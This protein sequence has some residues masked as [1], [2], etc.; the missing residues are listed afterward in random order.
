MDRADLVDLDLI[1]HSFAPTEGPFAEEAGTRLSALWDACVRAFDLDRPVA[2]LDAELSSVLDGTF[3]TAPV[4][5]RQD[6]AGRTQ[7]VARHLTHDAVGLSLL[8]PARDWDSA[9]GS[10]S[11]VAGSVSAGAWLG[12]CLLYSATVCGEVSSTASAGRLIRDLAP[13][14]A[15]P[16][17]P[18]WERTGTWVPSGKLAVW[19]SPVARAARPDRVLFALASADHDADATAVTWWSDVRAAP[20]LV[21]YLV[22]AARIRYQARVWDHG[23][24]TRDL[25]QELE[26]ALTRGANHT[27]R[28]VETEVRLT[29]GRLEDLL[30]SAVIIRDNLAR[31]LGPVDA[32]HGGFFDDDR[33]FADWFVQ[34][35]TDDLDH[36]RPMVERARI[37]VRPP[38]TVDRGGLTARLG[39][40]VDV[41]GYGRRSARQREGLNRRLGRVLDEVLVRVGPVADQIREG[42]GDGGFAFLPVGCDTAA[43]LR[44]LIGTTD[45]ALARD[46]ADHTDRMRIRMAVDFGIVGAGGEAADNGWRGLRGPLVVDLK[47]FVDCRE[48]RAVESGDLA[49][50]VSDWL[51]TQVV[52]HGYLEPDFAF[53]PVAVREKE[54]DTTGWVWVPDRAARRSADD[55]ITEE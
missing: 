51:H 30:R 41:V 9:T 10:W 16:L 11:R 24:H 18:G 13:T 45:A 14:T 42:T 26:S 21:R 12:T 29:A 55:S 37:E 54:L 27:L 5:A 2:G 4:V 48:L 49:V 32:P 44:E 25:R 40:V 19:E 31:H 8:L 1:A 39:V 7:I 23:K 46:N 47:R 36:L 22:Q 33:E 50:I 52:A 3:G 35:I 34:A 17:P 20:P 43:A 53:R 15:A 6:G 28:D 38:A